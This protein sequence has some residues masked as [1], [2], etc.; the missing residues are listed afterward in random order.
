[1]EQAAYAGKRQGGN[2]A[3][4][5]E[6]FGGGGGEKVREEGN[7]QIKAEKEEKCDIEGESC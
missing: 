4:D 2:R 3:G 1:M 7:K 6:C 5:W